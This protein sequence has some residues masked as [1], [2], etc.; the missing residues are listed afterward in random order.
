MTSDAKPTARVVTI[1][2]TYGAG[3]AA[4]AVLLAERLGL[5]FADR[6][7]HPHDPTTLSAEGVT[8]AELHEAPQGTV[9]RSLAL[10]GSAWNQP[11]PIDPDRDP[12]RM[13][14]SLEDG[15][16]DLCRQGGA[17]ILGRGAAVAIG[18]RRWAFHV[19]LDG[20][21]DRRARR[22]AAWEGISLEAARSRLEATDTT[23][24]RYSHRL[25][26]RDSNDPTLYHVVLDATVLTAAACVELLAIAAEDSWAYDEDRVED[27][28]AESAHRVAA[29]RS[30]R[31]Q[32]H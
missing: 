6:I 18:R 26:G 25:Y 17:V 19:R 1:S 20:P 8:S 14:Q 21:P 28:V 16:R 5:P 4:V 9:A 11:S 15:I 13:R 10:L 24:S 7:I 3:G 12:E 32:D 31:S 2:S 22:G 27:A 30:S 29:L 23:R